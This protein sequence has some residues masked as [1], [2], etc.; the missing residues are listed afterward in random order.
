[1][2]SYK[3]S[4][5]L[6]IMNALK[7]IIAIFFGPFL[8][9]YFI[10]V[11]TESIIDLSL[12]NIMNYIFLG[13]GGIVVGWIIRNKFQIGMFRVGIISNFI[14]ILTIIIMKENILDHLTLVS[15]LYGFSAITYYY[16]HNLFIAS[17]I[18]NKER[19]EYEFKKK[20]IST[21][22]A[23]ITPIILGGIIT[24]TNFELTATIILFISLLQ[25]ILSFFIKPIENR[26]Y[27]FTPIKSLKK[28]IK[29]KDIVNMLW[30]DYFKGMNVSEGALEVVL[31]IL[32]FNSFKTDLNLGIFSSLSSIFIIVM[33]YLYIK[34]FKNKNNKTIILLCSIIPIL[35]LLL[36]LI[37][38]NNITLVLYYFCYN[39]FVNVLSLILDVKLFNITKCET[40]KDD[41]QMEFWSI[42]EVVLNL[43]RI[44]GY[45]L[46][47]VIGIINR[48]NYLYYLM[49]LLTLSIAIMSYN[50][51]KVGN[52]DNID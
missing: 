1:M 29:N 2:I 39:T 30:V 15:F 18:N 31:T 47:F 12:Y 25:I 45:A 35:S 20:T 9:A 46:L 3:E 49:I 28:V 42:R 41:N 51:S 19:T 37:F 4:D 48:F 52:Y 14:Y 7:K 13:I 10:K 50:A 40:I 43:G 26:N 38:T 44:T 23:I 6:I 5:I 27:K 16:P 24:T 33:Q 8:T 32:I 11:S 34:K 21:I 36:L 17:K 22:T